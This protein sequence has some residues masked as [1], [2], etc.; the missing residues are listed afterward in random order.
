MAQDK[1]D[2]PAYVYRITRRGSQLRLG[3][4]LLHITHHKNYQSSAG[5]YS[6]LEY[7]RDIYQNLDYLSGSVYCYFGNHRNVKIDIENAH[8]LKSGTI[9]YLIKDTAHSIYIPDSFM[10]K[11]EDYN[12]PN[13]EPHSLFNELKKR[14]GSKQ[15]NK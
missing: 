9:N 4:D 1:T 10:Q 11:I 15:D 6:I 3:L 14:L 13:L 2:K 12:K 5:S 7:D 8:F